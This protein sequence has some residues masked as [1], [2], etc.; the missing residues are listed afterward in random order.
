MLRA[1]ESALSTATTSL[2]FGSGFATRL[3]VLPEWS[4]RHFGPIPLSLDDAN[5]IIGGIIQIL[6]KPEYS[7]MVVAPGTI[8]FASDMVL[9][10]CAPLLVRAASSNLVGLRSFQCKAADGGDTDGTDEGY[11]WGGLTSRN[12]PASAEDAIKIANA[13]NAA[14]VHG[15]RPDFGSHSVIVSGVKLAVEICLDHADSAAANAMETS[16]F[17]EL[18][19]G[20]QILVASGQRLTQPVRVA[21][22]GLLLRVDGATGDFSEPADRFQAERVLTSGMWCPEAFHKV[23]GFTSEVIA[24]VKFVTVYPMPNDSPFYGLVLVGLANQTIP[25]L[26]ETQPQQHCP[27]PVPTP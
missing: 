5:K 16:F 9:F 15:S 4:F 20:I 2:D 6:G 22:G 17:S 7:N 12:R 13:R 14:N 21:A 18:P 26:S 19:H 10:N 27:V 11:I 24:P 8:H 23:P 1:F 3:F 25:F